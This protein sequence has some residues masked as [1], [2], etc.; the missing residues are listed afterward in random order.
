MY[1]PSFPWGAHVL[2]RVGVSCEMILVPGGA[3]GGLL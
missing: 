3:M 2:L 1:H